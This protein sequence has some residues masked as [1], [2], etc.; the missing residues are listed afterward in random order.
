MTINTFLID[1]PVTIKGVSRKNYDDSYTIL[2]NSKL[3][4]EQRQS[5][6]LHEMQHIYNK[7]FESKASIDLTEMFLLLNKN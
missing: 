5:A 4:D 1:L 7:D 2:I 3:N 6:Y